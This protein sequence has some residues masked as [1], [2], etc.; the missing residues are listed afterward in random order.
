MATEAAYGDARDDGN[1][2]GNWK[3]GTYA[4]VGLVAIAEPRRRHYISIPNS[5]WNAMEEIE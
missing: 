5:Q 1:A 2:A 3:L 4:L